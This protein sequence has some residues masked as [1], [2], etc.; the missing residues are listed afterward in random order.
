M[1]FTSKHRK[2]TIGVIFK[3]RSNIFGWIL[4]YFSHSRDWLDIS[5]W[6]SVWLSE[7]VPNCS[8]IYC[9]LLQFWVS[10]FLLNEVE[11]WLLS[12]LSISSY[13]HNLYFIFSFIIIIFFFNIFVIKFMC[14]W[15]LYSRRRLVR[16]WTNISITNHLCWLSIC[17]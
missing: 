15:I 13:V 8:S 5:L 14:Y 4:F 2:R 12:Q 11:C 10:F 1:I 9:F 17:L 7:G 6:F 3:C 16:L